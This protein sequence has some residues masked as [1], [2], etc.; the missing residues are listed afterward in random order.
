MG[1]DANPGAQ[2]DGFDLMPQFAEEVVN[3][4]AC[5]QLSDG[6]APDRHPPAFLP[7][8]I[9]KNESESQLSYMLE[10]GLPRAWPSRE[11]CWP[12]RS[13]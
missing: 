2:T 9:L 12:L 10:W 7:R 13:L 8:N 6:L 3:D 1:G 5:R 11:T 4:L